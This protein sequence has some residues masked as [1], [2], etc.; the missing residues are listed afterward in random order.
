MRTILDVSELDVFNQLY[1]IDLDVP[2]LSLD[3]FELDM[4]NWLRTIQ[5]Y[6]I[7]A[8]NRLSGAVDHG[9]R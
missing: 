3:V 1:T 2:R 9:R 4:S 5:L 6:T 7:L 8:V